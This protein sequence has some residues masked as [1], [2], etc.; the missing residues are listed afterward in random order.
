M[1]ETT[2][3]EGGARE[4]PAHEVKVG[5]V[6]ATV[7]QNAGAN[8]SWYSVTL[9]RLYKDDQDQWKDAT[10]FGREDLLAVAKAADLAHTWV[11]SATGDGG[12]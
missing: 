12:R 11:L 10:S 9:S 3:G 2:S 4:R 7:W 8:G 6:R 1:A 5:A